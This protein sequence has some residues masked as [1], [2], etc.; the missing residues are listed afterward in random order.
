MGYDAL[1]NILS[2]LWNEGRLKYYANA[3]K[4]EEIQFC[5]SQRVFDGDWVMEVPRPPDCTARVLFGWA[6]DYCNQGSGGA[7]GEEQ[8][9][10]GY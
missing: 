3:K 5:W 2:D 1:M 6:F 4:E 9:H 8:N 10:K 7:R